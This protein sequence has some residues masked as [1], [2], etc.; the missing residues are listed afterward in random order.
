MGLMD[1]L[2]GLMGGKKKQAAPT[3]GGLGGLE[4]MLPGGLGALMG[5]NGG[6]L[7]MLLPLL[8]GSGALGNLGGLGGLLGKLKQGGLGAKADSWVGTGDNHEVTGD[9]L[10]NALGKDTVAKMAAEAGIGH[11][12]AKTGLAKMLPKLVNE[13]TPNGSVPSTSDLGSLV[14]GLDLSKLM[15]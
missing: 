2:G 10:E 3:S 15:G 9:E 6:M 7:K 11:D 4:S 12:E 13:V 14:K 5:G 8:L 1:I